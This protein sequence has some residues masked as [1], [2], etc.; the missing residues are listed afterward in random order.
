M[1]I[2]EQASELEPYISRG[3]YEFLELAVTIVGDFLKI[4]WK[5]EGIRCKHGG[6]ILAYYQEKD[7][8]FPNLL[9]AWN[10]ETRGHL[11]GEVH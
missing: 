8:Y 11:D 1:K 6:R 9:T 7:L 4:S 10:Q 2:Y 3:Y 5:G